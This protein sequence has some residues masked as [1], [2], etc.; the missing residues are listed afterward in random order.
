M[1]IDIMYDGGLSEIA[2]IVSD[3]IG[4]IIAVGAERVCEN[5][6]A[7]CPVDTGAL[8][9]SI[10]TECEGNR[11]EISAGTDYS[12]YVEFGTVFMAP[13]PYLVPALI[14]SSASVLDAMAQAI[15]D[16]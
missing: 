8:R 2:D 3:S 5:A 6:K 4:E 11:A 14:D 13:Q 15:T 1:R 10:H 9:E 7:M 16:I 12:A